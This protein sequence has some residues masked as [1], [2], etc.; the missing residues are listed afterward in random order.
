MRF[1]FDT[2]ESLCDIPKWF[3]N[4]TVVCPVDMKMQ[5]LMTGIMLG[6]ARYSYAISHWS[7]W[8]EHSKPEE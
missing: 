8:A 7:L 3:Y 1:L 2:H 4:L 5:N 6:G